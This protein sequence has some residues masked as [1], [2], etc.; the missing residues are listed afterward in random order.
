MLQL[1][2]AVVVL[3][4]AQ[5]DQ[6]KLDLKKLNRSKRFKKS[7][8]LKKHLLK[9]RSKNNLSLRRAEEEQDLV[10]DVQEKS[11]WLKNQLQNLS[12]NQNQW[13]KKPL[14]RKVEVVGDQA[15]VENQRIEIYLHKLKNNNLKK[16]SLLR[17]NVVV[18][19]L[20]QVVNQNQRPMSLKVN[21]AVHVQ[22][23]VENQNQNLM[24]LL[25]K[26]KEVVHV[27]VLAV[28]Q[29]SEWTPA[30]TLCRRRP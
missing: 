19:D 3:D 28:N 23:Q 27:Q 21:G 7:Q 14:S 2:K 5:V 22:V 25:L 29:K 16:S 8:L 4:Q 15:L 6:E 10:Q 11:S 17:N 20:V 18:Q 1:K 24:N 13:L 12:L 26:N 30:R 9:N